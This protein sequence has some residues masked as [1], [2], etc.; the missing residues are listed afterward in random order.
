MEMLFDARY[1][2][3]AGGIL[4][5]FYSDYLREVG[6]GNRIG[7]FIRSYSLILKLPSSGTFFLWRAKKYLSLRKVFVS[8]RAGRRRDRKRQ[9]LTPS[10]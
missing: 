8:A 9:S 2:C 4:H 7:S 3:G 5:N 6:C 10:V 1:Y